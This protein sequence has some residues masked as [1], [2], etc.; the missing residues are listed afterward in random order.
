[1]SA[2]PELFKHEQVKK[3]MTVSPKNLKTQ[4]YEDFESRNRNAETWTEDRVLVSLT[5]SQAPLIVDVGAYQGMS[6]IR[7]RKL[8]PD[9]RLVC[10][11]PNPAARDELVRTCNELGGDI[12]VSDC[13]VSDADGSASFFVQGINP[14]LSGL[15]R[16]SLNSKDSIAITKGDGTHLGQI[17]L[18]EI[19]VRT[20]RLDSMELFDSVDVD[21][22]KI[23]VQSCEAKVL[24]GAPKLLQRTS[25]VMIEVSFYDFYENM[26]SFS[27][28]E[29]FTEPAGLRLWAITTHSRNPMNGRT[30]W[31]NVVYSRDRAEVDSYVPTQP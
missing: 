3:D 17:N 9:A 21:L 2:F 29:E 20:A 13:A 4:L 27:A 6:A 16:R 8:F 1:M 11:E 18:E 23:D 19:K 31:V 12:K 26:S 22:L 30:D 5:K 10:F 25:V 15:A 24:R 28:I 14:G 7:F